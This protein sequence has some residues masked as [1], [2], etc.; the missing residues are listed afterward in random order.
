[1]SDKSQP[2]SAAQRQAAKRKRD[3]ADGW[4]TVTVRV[5][6]SKVGDLKAF[7]QSLGEPGL[8]DAP[9]KI[10]PNQGNLFDD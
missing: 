9:N 5:P 4:Q 1:M 10:N 7:A 6:V 3:Q 2:L 8:A